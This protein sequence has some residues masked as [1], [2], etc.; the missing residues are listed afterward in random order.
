MKRKR[1]PG[2]GPKTKASKGIERHKKINI[3]VPPDL[4]ASVEALRQEGEGDS[5]LVQ[6]VLR[7]ALQGEMMTEAE[8]HKIILDTKPD[9]VHKLKSFEVLNQAV[10]Y[11]KFDEQPLTTHIGQCLQ[12]GLITAEETAQLLSKLERVRK[13]FESSLKVL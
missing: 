4:W 6:R 2:A 13:S 7:I 3:T 10:Q 1:A 9:E 8:L 11:L 12:D 5:L